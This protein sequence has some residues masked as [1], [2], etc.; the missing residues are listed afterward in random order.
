MTD[1]VPSRGLPPGEEP[2]QPL[3]PETFVQRLRSLTEAV[4]S[5][6]R[7]RAALVEQHPR[8]ARGLSDSP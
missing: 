8:Y 5:L 6:R 7:L 3:T 1:K 4:R 2:I